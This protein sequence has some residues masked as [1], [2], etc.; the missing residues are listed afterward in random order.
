ML[1]HSF[2]WPICDFY[3]KN[4][5]IHSASADFRC[6][7]FVIEWIWLALAVMKAL[8]CLVCRISMSYQSFFVTLQ[9]IWFSNSRYKETIHSF[10]P[11]TVACTVL[12]LQLRTWQ[13]W[14]NLCIRDLCYSHLNTA[15]F[16]GGWRKFSSGGIAAW[17]WQ[18]VVCRWLLNG[19]H[20]CSAPKFYSLPMV[21][22]L[23]LLSELHIIEVFVLCGRLSCAASMLGTS[24]VAA[25]CGTW[26]YWSF[27]PN[28]TEG[29]VLSIVWVVLMLYVKGLFEGYHFSW[30]DTFSVV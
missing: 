21:P 1:G 13:V 18:C 7:P 27:H 29:L 28:F 22:F 8:F 14:V 6:V 16:H 24:I 12:W 2:N 23:A 25:A 11:P 20:S 5:V 10:P 9:C 3:K 15:M 19:W 30:C 4:L 26:I 17:E